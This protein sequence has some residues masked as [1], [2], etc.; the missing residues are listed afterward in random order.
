MTTLVAGV[1]G[2][3]SAQFMN[4]GV[5]AD[6]TLPV[7]LTITPVAG[8]AAVLSTTDVVHVGTGTFS[9]SWTPDAVDEPTDYLVQWD[10]AG[11]EDIPAAEVVTVLPGVEGTWA[12]VAEV[13][14]VTGLERDPVVVT[15]AS[16]IIETYSGAVPDMPEA[17]ISAKDRRHLMRATAWQAAWLTPARVAT[18]TTERENAKSVSA[19][20]V[21]IER[22]S[23]SDGMLA[24]LAKRELVALSWVGTRS[25]MPLPRSHRARMWDYMNFLNE[26]S[27]PWWMGGP[28]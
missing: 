12:T 16:S 17:S 5:L 18:L 19:D 28:L 13:L 8:G 20:S 25:I 9:Y 27:D 15:L 21:R 14:A 10:G 4:N 23:A 22:E 6:P 1:P 7:T 24:P 11:V 2:T 3:L 26:K